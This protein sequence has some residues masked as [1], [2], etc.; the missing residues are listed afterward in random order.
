MKVVRVLIEHNARKQ[1]H[2]VRRRGA[3]KDASG[4]AI[5]QLALGI[6]ERYKVIELP[7]RWQHCGE[8]QIC[9]FFEIEALINGFHVYQVIQ[10]VA[11]ITQNAFIGNFVAIIHKVTM[12]VCH[13]RDAG[14]H[15][16]AVGIAQAALDG[17]FL[18]EAGVHFVDGVECIVQNEF[19]FCVIRHAT[20]LYVSDGTQPFGIVRGC[21]SAD[22]PLKASIVPALVLAL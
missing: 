1:V 15:A 21:V 18:V 6:N 19:L 13:V 5:G 17:V 20:S 7:L 22:E 3:K 12:N 2:D 10:V 4:E 8:Q 16:R 9:Y 11:T 14:N